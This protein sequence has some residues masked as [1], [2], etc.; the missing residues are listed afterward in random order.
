MLT[1]EVD[2]TNLEIEKNNK[3]KTGRD[4]SLLM[5]SPREKSQTI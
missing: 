5:P 4:T 1:R 2:L 3:L